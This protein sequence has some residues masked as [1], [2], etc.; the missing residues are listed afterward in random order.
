MKINE[1]N[2]YTYDFFEDTCK[3]LKNSGFNP[4]QILDIG[5]NACETA[6]IMRQYWPA[7]DML[8]IEGNSDCEPYFKVKNY[9]YLI[10]LLGKTNSITTFYKTKWSSVCSGNSIYKEKNPVYDEDML[11]TETL[12]IYKLDDVVAG[13]F[14]LI[15]IDTQGS[16][17]DIILGG[18]STVSK[19]KVVICE[20]SL[21][22]VN[23]GGCKKEDVMNVLTKELKFDYVRCIEKVLSPDNK[24]F[25][26][27]N[28]LFIK[29]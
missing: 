5:A 4:Q 20:V 21:I 26:Y 18:M 22:D 16:E 29:P 2:S 11:I 13:K 23:E 15:K 7:A 9:N 14:D 10:K 19:A 1:L 17:L 25:Y 8:L 28:L 12:P 27:E 6:D 24:S 3:L